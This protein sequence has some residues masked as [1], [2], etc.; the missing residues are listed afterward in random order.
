MEFG[1][2]RMNF[3][4][5]KFGKRKTLGILF[6]FIVSVNSYCQNYFLKTYGQREGLFAQT[7]FEI[8]QDDMGF[9]WIGTEAGLFRFDGYKVEKFGRSRGISDPSIFRI[10]KD[11]SGDLWFSGFSGDVFHLHQG[12][13]LSSDRD[14]CLKGIKFSKGVA[15][16]WKES[17]ST[18][19]ISGYTE[20]VYRIYPNRVP[21]KIISPTEMDNYY[22]APIFYTADKGQTFF[23]GRTQ[24]GTFSNNTF[25][26]PIPLKYPECD[27]FRIIWEQDKKGVLYLSDSGLVRMRGYFQELI[28]PTSSLPDKNEIA[29][30][31]L[32]SKNRLWITSVNGDCQLI[33]NYDQPEAKFIP[34]SLNE[35][36]NALFTEDRAGNLWFRV[37]TQNFGMLSANFESFSVIQNFPSE[38]GQIGIL[39]SSGGDFLVGHH[40]GSISW[41]GK[42]LKEL[43]DLPPAPQNASKAVKEL[44]E[45]SK[46]NIWAIKDNGLLFHQ[47]GMAIE[48]WQ[49]IKQ[50]A[51]KSI[52]ESPSGKIAGATFNKVY[53]I[54]T[55]ESGE[56]RI[57]DSILFT[58]KR[59]SQVCFDFHDNLYVASTDG[60]QKYNPENKLVHQFQDGAN[61]FPKVQTLK[62]LSDGTIFIGLKAQGMWLM[63]NDSIIQRVDGNGIISDLSFWVVRQQGQ[64]IYA[65]GSMGV[66]VFQF[67]EGKYK[68]TRH[69]YSGNGLTNNTVY[70]IWP[71]SNFLY[72]SSPNALVKIKLDSASI[73]HILP[74]I[75][76]LLFLSRGD[77]LNPA[78]VH[79]PYSK[80]ALSVS[81]NTPWFDNRENLVWAW[82]LTEKNG[83]DNWNI[84]RNPSVEFP[85][86]ESG[87]YQ[88]KLKSGFEDEFWGPA[89]SIPITVDYPF[90]RKI[91]F[92]LLSLLLIAGIPILFFN[93]RIRNI[94]FKNL[95]EKRQKEKILQLEMQARLAMMEPHFIFNVLNS[96]QNLLQKNDPI[97]ARDNMVT[98]ANLIRAHLELIN[99]DFTSL[100]KE[101]TFLN[102]YLSLEKL[103][104][105]GNLEYEIEVDPSL[106]ED[107]VSLPTM[108]VQP[109]VENALK[110]GISLRESGGKIN[111]RFEDTE[112]H[113]LISIIDNGP[114]IEK[115]KLYTA[116]TGI[117][118]KNTE[119]RIRI[120]SEILGQSFSLEFFVPFPDGEMK[121][122]GVRIRL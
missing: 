35:K 104:W 122:C 3:C 109:F 4:T 58:P 97:A 93:R 71:D 49:L 90:W 116:G 65:C 2:W 94:R 63:K 55:N 31:L 45:D 25:S 112:T 19:L 81:F 66:F 113:L 110:H 82:S 95:E 107:E 114:G 6:F 77:T 41:N 62:L 8:E 96:I 28:L 26:P 78:L 13:I 38:F 75:S 27:I 100:R 29:D 120:L 106:D 21:E 103:R 39:K 14:S 69:Y 42:N 115:A 101:L 7:V 32:D 70:D 53:F 98:F 44:F 102:D 111:I 89:V 1:I 80:S 88:L 46:G 57:S 64:T 73:P 105:E 85:M 59:V 11:N 50:S 16:A 40:N 22:T 84:I 10:I 54:G 60:F 86:L 37:S 121:G 117:G 18:W 83:I 24:T 43:I 48:K 17:D 23:L 91:W 87:K 79:L 108:I 68:I 15:E 12:K 33:I 74:Q 99:Q 34:I 30:I 36:A 52:S 51:W 76:D 61:A 20:G 119:E 92:Q 5:R 118:K 9:L 56:R 67:I 72:V 47:K